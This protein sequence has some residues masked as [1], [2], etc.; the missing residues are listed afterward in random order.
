MSTSLNFCQGVIRTEL[1][2]SLSGKKLQ[3]YPSVQSVSKAYWLINKKDGKSLPLLI[4]FL[5]FEFLK[6][7]TTLRWDADLIQCFRC[8]KF[9]HTQQCNVSSME[10]PAMYSMARVIMEKTHV[11]TPHIV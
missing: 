6:L 2:E 7:P 3:C 5:T 10:A 9:C 4:V 1:L 8:Q 11:Q